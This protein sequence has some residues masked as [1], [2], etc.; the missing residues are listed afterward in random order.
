MALSKDIFKEHKEPAPSVVLSDMEQEM[1][2]AASVENLHEINEIHDDLLRMEDIAVGLEDLAMVAGHVE[3]ASTT[4]AAFT[5][6]AMGLAVA[7]SGM[8]SEDLLPSVEDIEG[9]Q[10]SVEGIKDIAASVWESIKRAITKL[11]KKVKEFWRNL[12]SAIPGLR[13]AAVKLQKRA[14]EAV[15][16]S[17]EDKKVSLGRE[18]NALSVAHEAP[19]SSSEIVD[20]LETISSLAEV[21][22]GKYTKALDTVG[23]NLESALASIDPEKDDTVV[24]GLN[25]A[26]AA[27]EGALVSELNN[28]I[29]DGK[30]DAKEARF[31]RGSEVKALN[32]MGNKSMFR[33]AEAAG[34]SDLEKAEAARR[35][36]YAVMETKKKPKDALDGKDIDI[37][38][39][40]ACISI[41]DV[42]TKICDTLEEYEKKGNFNKIDKARDDLAKTS[43]SLDKAVKKAKK[44]EDYN[45]GNTALINSAINFNK[46][47]AD[48]TTKPQTSLS[49]L[50]VAACRAALVAGN[51]SLSKY[52]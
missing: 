45:K 33:I 23:S 40:E 48:W 2:I 50:A 6:V 32:L 26:T 41:A 30:V 18:V 31:S 20:G 4:D 14:E 46:A 12:T 8:Q 29:D 42:I 1:A 34:S 17:S 27:A 36:K 15:G 52:K 19:G 13:K 49:G 39:P 25:A 21:F 28:M 5:H 11:W 3:S 10:I 38:T 24:S 22:F 16:K 7:G 47:F 43:D 35:L 51:K 37:L 9:T 44:D